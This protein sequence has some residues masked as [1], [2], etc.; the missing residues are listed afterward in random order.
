MRRPAVLLLLLI[1]L[2]A[3]LHAE[4]G[5]PEAIVQRKFTSGGTIRLHL[6]SGGYTIR[7]ADSDD[8]VVTYHA[9]SE[10]RLRQVRVDIQPSA[11]SV[12]I[13][14]SNTPNNKFEA[15]IDVPRHSNLMGAAHR[16]RV[17]CGSRGR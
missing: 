16:W 14:V 5:S 10:F 17:G 15:T 11:S 8:I 3:I 7:P 4:N 2:P 1:A 12:E 6:E 13:F 9:S